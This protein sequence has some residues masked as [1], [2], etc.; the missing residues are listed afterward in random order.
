MDTDEIMCLGGYVSDYK[1]YFCEED[2][3]CFRYRILTMTF[4]LIFGAA[5]VTVLPF[6]GSISL[7]SA[8]TCAP[9]DFPLT[10]YKC[11]ISGCSYIIILGMIGALSAII[12]IKCTLYCSKCWDRLYK[13]CLANVVI[14]DNPPVIV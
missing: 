11:Y 8:I 9:V 4:W 1:K 13:R 2:V 5:F 14:N 10:N 7:I 6:I 3:P 12:V